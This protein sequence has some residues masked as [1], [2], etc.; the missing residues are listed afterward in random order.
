[1]KMFGIIPTPVVHRGQKKNNIFDIVPNLHF[2]LHFSLH[3][4]GY[5]LELCC[6]LGKNY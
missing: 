5:L 4:S 3:G 2:Y 6:F 1:M